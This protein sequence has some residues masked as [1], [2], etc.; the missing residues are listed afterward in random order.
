MKLIDQDYIMKRNSKIDS[1]LAELNSTL[2]L[3]YESVNENDT[4]SYDRKYN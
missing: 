2:D 3:Y 1:L 4:V